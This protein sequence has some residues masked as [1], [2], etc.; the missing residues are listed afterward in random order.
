M[1]DANAIL[2]KIYYDL[3]HPAGYSGLQSLVSASKLK[4]KTVK[5]WLSGENTYTLHK[6]RKN[7]FPRRRT[8][9]SGIRDTFQADLVSVQNLA[10]YNNGFQYFLTVIDVFSRYAWV[11]PIKNKKGSTIATA[12]DDLFSSEENRP[13]K[14]HTDL[15]SEFYNA[16]VKLILD[17]YGI[18]LYS[19]HSD[20]KASLVERFNRTIKGRLYRYFFKRNTYHYLDVLDKLVEGYNGRKHRSLGIAPIQVNETNEKALWKRLYGDQ[21]PK[22]SDNFK[23]ELDDFVRISKLSNVFQKKYVPLWTSEHFQISHRLA[24][25]PVTYKLKDTRGKTIR[26][27]FYESQLQKIKPPDADSEYPIKVLR[28]RKRGKE[29]LYLVDYIG[30]PEQYRE[31]L[32]AKQ[33]SRL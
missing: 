1:A 22:K 31:W 30:W 4:P 10:R 28:Q 14:L 8:I 15:G 33:V 13:R 16:H 11:I 3:A 25:Q 9:V 5:K 7:T 2:Q 17:K 18:S 6:P 12:F 21:F 23:F 26:G 32:N 29:T 19:V 20:T 24:T 27:S